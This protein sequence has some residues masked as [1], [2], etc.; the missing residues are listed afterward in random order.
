[1]PA[2]KLCVWREGGAARCVVPIGL[3]HAA[4]RMQ[5]SRKRHSLLPDHNC[6]PH[7]S[8]P[9]QLPTAPNFPSP[10]PPYHAP[11]TPV[12]ASRRLRGAYTY[13]VSRGGVHGVSRGGVHGVRKGGGGGGAESQGGEHGV[14]GVRGVHGVH[15]ERSTWS[16]W[17]GTYIGTTPTGS[18]SHPAPQ[19]PPHTEP[20]TG[21]M[22]LAM[23][24]VFA[25]SLTT[26]GGGSPASTTADRHLL[27]A[28]R[29]A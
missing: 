11:P 26:T 20:R 13:R 7:L 17:R 22:S 2:Y 21:S 9:N 4:P 14:R 15:G 10:S 16:T 23:S 18:V 12:P 28:P 6:P 25:P 8:A 1:M 3:A 27:T 5:A 19:P 29:V 24:M